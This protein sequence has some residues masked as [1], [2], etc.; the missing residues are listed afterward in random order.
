MNLEEIK[1]RDTVAISDVAA[2]VFKDRHAL[3]AEVERL[4]EENVD[5]KTIMSPVKLAE[6]A[7]MQIE[8]NRLQAENATLKKALDEA[9]RK[10]QNALALVKTDA[11]I[12]Q[13]L[14]KCPNSKV[15]ILY[16]RDLAAKIEECADFIKN[17]LTHETHGVEK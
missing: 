15:E 4:T 1:A 16:A 7:M 9:I 11:K 17:Q 10:S 13:N 14:H 6:I 8:F 3:I 2:L 12:I 5:L